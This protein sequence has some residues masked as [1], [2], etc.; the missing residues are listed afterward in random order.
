MPG[1]S[2]L[3]LMS[4]L[5]DVPPDESVVTETREISI[6]QHDPDNVDFEKYSI[7]NQ[8]EQM[9]EW[10]RQ[11]AEE[12]LAKKQLILEEKRLAYEMELNRQNEAIIDE[13]YIS[14]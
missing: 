1:Q 13:A 10:R 11:I 3:A 5:T 2:H 14:A 7:I 12:H 4:V 9:V 8:V 6:N